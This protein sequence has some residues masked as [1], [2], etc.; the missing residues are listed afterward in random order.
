MIRTTN[1][2]LDKTSGFRLYISMEIE[3]I[4]KW[5]NHQQVILSVHDGKLIIG[6]SISETEVPA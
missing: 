6:S 1:I 2:Y 3:N 4:L 5:E